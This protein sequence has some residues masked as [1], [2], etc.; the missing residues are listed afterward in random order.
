MRPC[1]L[2]SQVATARTRQV[3][4]IVIAGTAMNRGPLLRWSIAGKTHVRVAGEW[5]YLCRAVDQHGQVIDLLLSVRPDLAEAPPIFSRE[6]ASPEE[7][8]EADCGISDDHQ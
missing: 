4:R 1:H 7:G 8:R 3:A 6:R 2:T 5:A